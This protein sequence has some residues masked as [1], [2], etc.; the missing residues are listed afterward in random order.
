VYTGDLSY[1]GE[2]RL[3]TDAPAGSP[4]SDR[5]DVLRVLGEGAGGVVYLA[6]DRSSGETVAVKTLRAGGGDMLAVLRNEF[7]VVSDLHHPNLV[8]VRELV[9]EGDHWFLSM[10]YVDGV[11]FQH[12]VQGEQAGDGWP[13]DEARLR[14][15]LTQLAEALAAL[16][17]AGRIHRD[18]KPSNVLVTREGRVVVLDFGV[19]LDE[20]ALISRADD[21]LTGTALY[22]APE[23]VV[24]ERVGPAADWYAVGAMLYRAL[25]GRLPFE[26]PSDEVMEAKLARLPTDPRRIQPELPADLV[27]LCQQLLEPFP[28]L[29]PRDADV[30]SRLGVVQGAATSVPPGPDASCVGR[31]AQLV[32]LREAHAEASL[33]RPTTVLVE[34]ES[35]IGKSMFAR[36]FA[37]ELLSRPAPAPVL[38]G[39]CYEREDAPFKAFG[40]VVEALAAHLH[41]LP[42]VELRALVPEGAGLLPRIF[43]ELGK[44][45][46][47]A[48]RAATPSPD[49]KETRRRTFAA[50]CELVAGVAKLSPSSAL[51]IVIDDLQWADRDSLELLA[52]LTRPPR[53]RRLLLVCTTRIVSDGGRGSVPPPATLPLAGEQ[54]RVRLERLDH[55]ASL[56]V[57]E[58][59]CQRLDLRVEPA[60]VALLIE[61]ASGHPMFLGELLRRRTAG[62][63]DRALRLDDTLRARATELPEK[64]QRLLEVVCVAG[65][66]LRYE[67]AREAAGLLPDEL[68]RAL[69]SLRAEHLVNSAGVGRSGTVEPYHDR[70]R[71]AVAGALEGELLRDCHARLARAIEGEEAPEPEMLSH[72]WLEAGSSARAAT[73][74]VV[75]AD[76]ANAALAF[77]HAA[78]LYELA[79]RLHE[80]D[81]RRVRELR[82][83]LAE[84]L[85]NAGHWALS[86]E[87]RLV[88]ADEHEG[89]E[90]LHLRRLAAEQLLCSGHFD[91]GARLIE[92]LLRSLGMF[93]PRSPLVVLLSVLVLKLMLRIRGLCHVERSADE[94]SATELA[95]LDVLASA[96]SGLA[97]TD[98][99]L[100]T[101]FLMRGALLALK[102]GEPHRLVRSLAITAATR[103]AGGRKDAAGAQQLTEA[104]RKVAATLGT[105]VSLALSLNAEAHLAYCTGRWTE[106]KPTMMR[107]EAIYR[108]QCIGV[109]FL[110]N[111]ARSFLY[112]ILAQ[113]GDIAELEAKLEPAL[114]ELDAIGDVFSATIVRAGPLV[115]LRLAHD[116]PDLAASELGWVFERLARSRYLLQHFF[117]MNAKV[118]LHLYEGEFAAAARELE[119]NEKPLGR[120]LLL[121]IAVLRTLVHEQRGRAALALAATASKPALLRRAEREARI[122]EREEMPFAS[123]Y[124]AWL[125]AGV[126][127]VRGEGGAALAKAERAQALFER[128]DMELAAACVQ[129]ARGRMLGGSEGTAIVRKA[130]ARL[131]AA[132][133]RNP[134]RL[135]ASYAAGWLDAHCTV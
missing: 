69:S 74:T 17:G 73:W 119:D 51:T 88:L 24:G 101:Y 4:F 91:R 82:F 10:E 135:A 127:F 37:E 97:L 61:E 121:R 128:A 54:R 35:G 103:A 12:Y 36:A 5:F 43:P 75:A 80:G 15:S 62:S 72:H 19:A 42:E 26:G 77:E 86:A 124:A 25:T 57:C 58:A 107:A 100:S 104:T 64:A 130:E 92:E 133:V 102:V 50:F 9:L 71:E 112:R 23:Q 96:G 134:A 20:S 11:D 52:E 3:S 109:A 79:M 68:A 16:H 81:A 28:E 116:R 111:G 85:T 110:W 132:G 59:L 113:R 114:R 120:S 41:T 13:F 2:L 66:P 93:V 65:L 22:M 99:F 21:G 60:A 63:L 27:A 40:T 53:Q 32:V 87:H 90:A 49:P 70:I 33:G 18:I 6:V 56:R 129:H 45:D 67:T 44:V 8:Q 29:R 83:K 105:P 106:A 89:L 1:R 46:A 126:A 122:L 108:E 31:E 117:Y 55:A 7:R 47:I 131:T 78:R 48:S 84:A 76:R 115:L 30:L 125:R 98:L 118:N 14:R 94:V 34:G 95:R 38:F 123:A 39:R